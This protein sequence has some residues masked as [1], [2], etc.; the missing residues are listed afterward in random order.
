M[1]DN[2][3]CRNRDCACCANWSSSVFRILTLL[4]AIVGSLNI[5]LSARNELVREVAGLKQRLIVY[6]NPQTP[7]SK[8]PIQ[9]KDR[10]KARNDPD[11]AAGKRRP[12]A[13]PGHGKTEERLPVDAE[14]LH[15]CAKCP[16]CQGTDLSECREEDFVTTDIPRIVRAV[17][18]RHRV[19]VYR[20]NGCGLGEIRSESVRTA[21]D[22]ARGSCDQAKPGT[23]PTE[24]A[25]GQ[26]AAVPGQ[27]RRGSVH[28]PRSGTYGL[29]VIAAILFNFMGRLPHRLNAVSM[30][31]MGLRMSVGTVHNILCR[32]RMRL[33]PSSREILERIRGAHVLHVDETSLSLNGSL[34][35][36]WIFLNPE[37]GDAYYAIRR[38]RGGGVLDEMLG[39][40]WQ[41]KIVCD[42]LTPYR[43]YRIQRC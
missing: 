7:S 6:D 23:A 25:A 15:R 35:W 4:G 40:S 31:R 12:G 36:L 20:C 43:K 27:E 32:T 9:Q 11:G 30:A 21:E 38:S 17:T 19:L 41:G 2:K 3:A 26:D 42:G 37:T 29:N 34:V 18:V 39:K 8:K 22:A 24:R 10:R 1:G 13:Q 28:R 16:G 14:E 33:E 5:A